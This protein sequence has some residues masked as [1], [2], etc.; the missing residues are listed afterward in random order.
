ME[1][2]KIISKIVNKMQNGMESRKDDQHTINVVQEIGKSFVKAIENIRQPDVNV[3]VPEIKIPKIEV[4]VPQVTI[5]ERSLDNV[6]IKNFD[7]FE[8][9]LFKVLTQKKDSKIDFSGL[10]Q[11][12]TQDNP[13]PVVLTYEGKF[14]EAIGTMVSGMSRVSLK[15]DT[16]GETVN[17]A[18][19]ENQDDT[20]FNYKL[21]DIDDSTTTYL[22]YLRKDGA[23]YIQK[24]TSAG[25]VTYAAGASG[26]N[27][28]NRTSETYAIFSTT[29]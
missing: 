15:N 12:I 29:F 5:N 11:T 24:I 22:G 2:D 20:L 26:Y 10:S 4:P 1:Q 6:T 25:A 23:W 16:T 19:S 21:S 7:K 3:V 9:K 28:S 18:T 13:L 27:F 14:Y 8:E 17:P